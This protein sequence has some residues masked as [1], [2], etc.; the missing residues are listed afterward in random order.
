MSL[1][2]CASR[3]FSI[4]FLA[5][6]VLAA[7]GPAEAAGAPV[8][9]A[10]ALNPNAPA[11]TVKLIFIHHSTGQNWLQDGYGNLG[12]ELSNNNYFVSDTNYGWG[13]NSI[14]D[15]TDIPNWIEWFR[16]ASTP[17]YMSAL[18]TESGQHS[19]YTRTRP[20]PGGQNTII[21]FKSCFP[22]SNLAGNP[23]DPPDPTPGLTVGHAKYV[24]NQILKYFRTR[25]DKLFVVITAPPV[26]DST[27]AAN[28]RAFNM[29]LMYNWL[30][31]NAYPFSN[32]AVFDFYNV[33]THP[34]AHH[35][36]NSTTGSIEH[37][38]VSGSNTLYYPSSGGDDHP[39]AL[40]SQKATA[41]FVPLLNVFYNRWKAEDLPQTRRFYPNPAQDGWVLESAEASNIGGR[42]NGIAPTIFLGDNAVRRQYRGILS[43]STGATLPDNAV[44]T[45]VKLRIRRQ[46]I[47]GSSNP[48]N[49]F[50]GLMVDLMKGTFGTAAL[51]LSDFQSKALSSK[52][53][54]LGP[55]KPAADASG[56]YTI[57]LPIAASSYINKLATSSG[58]TQVRL[59]FQ[60]DDNN[61]GV[62]NYLSVYSANAALT[63]Q[64]QLLIQYYVP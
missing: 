42:V 25:P 27:Y 41:E 38:F 39:N 26:T 45:S 48:V 6:F 2:I 11:Q 1:R 14:G 8:A 36:Y 23:T 9:H 51:E 4:L 3:L 61:D 46:A 55:Y 44:I 15:R 35:R 47:V 16:S 24:Y 18:F 31:S 29:W 37:I 40:G 30:P 7:A 12:K 13:P 50:Q 56:W 59:R 43:F 60:L 58:L 57:A 28:A 19:S 17:T 10:L 5:V 62:A 54:S 34:N 20:N 22:N 49:L 63:S 33:L 53:R 64:P 32:V 21:M 52:Y